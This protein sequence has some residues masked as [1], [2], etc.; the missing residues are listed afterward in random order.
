MRK[1][2]VLVFDDFIAGS[3]TVY[4][5]PELNDQLGQNDLLALQAIVDQVAVAAGN[6]TVQIYHSA[7][8]INWKTKNGTAEINA[9]AIA[10]NTTNVAFGSDG[11]T[12]PS[13][14]FVRLGITIAAVSAQAH[15]KLWVTGRNQG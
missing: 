8:Q 3:S 9:V 4:T 14:G 12:V 11:G 15:V 6:V 7:D 2:N 13:L 5:R 1:M 10:V